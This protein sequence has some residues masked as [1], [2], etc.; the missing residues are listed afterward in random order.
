MAPLR[1]VS[2]ERPEELSRFDLWN[3]PAWQRFGHV[4]SLSLGD[5]TFT[6]RM[7]LGALG[8][9]S[10]CR[11]TAAAHR[12]EHDAEAL[13]GGSEARLKI[14]IQV[15]GSSEFQQGDK[16]VCLDAG[17]FVLYDPASAYSVLNPHAVEQIVMSV[18][19]A[20]LPVGRG[21]SAQALGQRLMGA[22]GSARLALALLRT[23]LAE[24]PHCD[25]DAAGHVVTMICRLLI[26]AVREQTQPMHAVPLKLVLRTR[27]RDFIESN[28]TDPELDVETIA[29]HLNCSK[30]YLHKVFEDD[31]LTVARYIWRRRLECSKDELVNPNR[32]QRPMS[33]VALAWGFS[34]IAHFSRAF[35]QEFGAP[36]SEFRKRPTCSG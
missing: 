15:H 24:L 13:V 8:L 27:V 3:D 9:I 11:I 28:L 36:P 33:E 17:D 31:G 2:R 23:T 25:D 18:P 21:V 14:L 6:G 35:K 16:L 5:E 12:V 26:G 4:R 10:L 29:S 30:R 20:L 1:V 7:E 19:A 34:G 22:S 32:L